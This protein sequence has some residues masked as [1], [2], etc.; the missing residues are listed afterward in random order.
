MNAENAEMLLRCHRAGRRDDA[1]TEKAVRFAEA[2]PVLGKKLSE[3]A[4]FDDK[5]VGVI[6]YIQPPENLRQK[7]AEISAKPGGGKR[8]LLHPAILPAVA[9]V[10]LLLGIMVFL[11][12]DRRANF[13]GR[14]AVETLIMKTGKASGGEFEAVAAPAGEM[15]DWFF[16][17]GFDGYSL[18]V[19]LG[20]LPAT[21]ARVFKSDNGPVAQFAVEKRE[22]IVH[23]FRVGDFGVDL[24]HGETWR[25][26]EHEG[27]A[28]ALRR[29]GGNCYLL[30]FRGSK[31]EMD[32]YLQSLSKP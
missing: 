14:D 13:E 1:R 17:H 3:Q 12:M 11:E 10:L 31:A 26:F 21:F 19:E 8:K 23:V 18:P 22:M 28:A 7:L 20:P 4:A 29:H 5:V 24:P 16:V 27:W 32:D 15:G 30:A 6:H 2:D 25:T 9:G